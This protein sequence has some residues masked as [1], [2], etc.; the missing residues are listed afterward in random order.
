[1]T[2]TIAA[3]TADNGTDPPT[4]STLARRYESATGRR[5]RGTRLSPWESLTLAGTMLALVAAVTALA[6]WGMP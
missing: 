6:L 4:F 3:P 1:M 5:H 2:Q